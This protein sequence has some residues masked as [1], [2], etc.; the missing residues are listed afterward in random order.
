MF[1]IIERIFTMHSKQLSLFYSDAPA[2]TSSSFSD[3]PVSTSG[4]P[5]QTSSEPASN[6]A[7]AYDE[8]RPY[9]TLMSVCPVGD[10]VVYD[11]NP[12]TGTPCKT[13]NGMDV[14]DYSKMDKAKLWLWN[15]FGL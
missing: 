4:V 2:S 14:T 3:A 7:Q 11:T 15:H 8:A 6:A 5:S 9:H 13:V 1:V 12:I 10:T